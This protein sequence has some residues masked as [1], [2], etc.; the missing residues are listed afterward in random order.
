MKPS[1][2]AKG[3]L[4]GTGLGV[5]CVVNSPVALSLTAWKLTLGTGFVFGGLAGMIDSDAELNMPN[6]PTR[7]TVGNNPIEYDNYR[8]NVDTS[9]PFYVMRH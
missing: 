2:I 4:I 9:H 3:A 1:S 5:I 8:R 6:I 7:A